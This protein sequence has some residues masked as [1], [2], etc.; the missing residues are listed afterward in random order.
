MVEA[1]ISYVARWLPIAGHIFWG[2]NPNVTGTV[3]P[4]CVIAERPIW[5]PAGPIGAPGGFTRA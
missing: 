4:L 2:D 3:Q 1:I 5:G